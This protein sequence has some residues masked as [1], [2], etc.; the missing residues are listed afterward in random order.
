MMKVAPMIPSQTMFAVNY[1]MPNIHSAPTPHVRK[2]CDQL[3]TGKT[4]VFMCCVSSIHVHIHPLWGLILPTA[5]M[6]DHLD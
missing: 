2:L 1:V 5:P 4:R 6:G 3:S